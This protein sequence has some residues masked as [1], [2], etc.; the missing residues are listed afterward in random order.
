MTVITI[1]EQGRTPGGGDS[2]TVHF[3]HQGEYAATV[4]NPFS[5][6]LEE[7][8]EWYF[9]EHL[10]YPFTDQVRAREVAS[11]I[12]GYGERVFGQVFD[13]REAF[14]QYKATGAFP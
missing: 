12:P 7:E 13:D 2:A 1:R 10:R 8:L 9:E 6:E 5:A 3:D 14:A 4:A 11:L